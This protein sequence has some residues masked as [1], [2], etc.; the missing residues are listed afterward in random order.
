LTAIAVDRLA[1]ATAVE[2]V[3]LQD[4][5]IGAGPVREPHRHDDHELICVRAGSGQHLIDGAPVPVRP[6]TV[7]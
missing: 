4:A 6:G 5:T 3:W 2:A 7:T 1:Q